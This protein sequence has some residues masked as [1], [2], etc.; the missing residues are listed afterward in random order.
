MSHS[1]AKSLNEGK[2]EYQDKIEER[3]KEFALKDKEISERDKEYEMMEKDKDVEEI[4]EKT[5]SNSVK[6]VKPAQQKIIKNNVSTQQ[7]NKQ[8]INN[9]ASFLMQNTA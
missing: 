1:N 9:D 5:N 8:Q 4:N 2:K 6:N 7:L 3:Q